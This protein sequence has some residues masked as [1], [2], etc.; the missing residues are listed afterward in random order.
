VKFIAIGNS[1]GKSSIGELA[2]TGNTIF[3][4]SDAIV[5]TGGTV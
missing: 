5:V 1:R 2:E 3:T 4:V